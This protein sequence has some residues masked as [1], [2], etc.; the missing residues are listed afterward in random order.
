MSDRKL[1]DTHALAKQMR[2]HP[3]TIRRMCRAKQIPFVKIDG[4]YRFD[5]VEVFEHFIRLD[6]VN[7]LN[8]I[9]DDPRLPVEVRKNITGMSDGLRDGTISLDRFVNA[10]ESVASNA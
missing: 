7:S 3:E 6:I 10:Y 9:L 8:D 5:S 4:E 2:K 1:I